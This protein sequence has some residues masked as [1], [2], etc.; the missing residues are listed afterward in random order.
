MRIVSAL[1]A[2]SF[3]STLTGCWGPVDKGQ[4]GVGNRITPQGHGAEWIK[5]KTDLDGKSP[6]SAGAAGHA[7]APASGAAPASAAH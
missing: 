6:V 5:L 3:L 7:A 2:L 4:P 1:I